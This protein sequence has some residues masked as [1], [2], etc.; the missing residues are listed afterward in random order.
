[1]NQ[2]GSTAIALSQTPIPSP[3][4]SLCKMNQDTELCEG[5]WRTLDE[6]M[7]WGTASDA[8]KREIWHKIALRRA[9]PDRPA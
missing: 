1:M 8:A 5:C 6:I 7:L 4:V 3:C 2:N 9:H